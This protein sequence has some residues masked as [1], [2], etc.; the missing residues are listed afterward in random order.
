MCYKKIWKYLINIEKI[1]KEIRANEQE[2]E[3]LKT[4]VDEFETA[5]KTIEDATL[6]TMLF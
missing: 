5:I 6:S 1:E 4:E 3:V 2:T